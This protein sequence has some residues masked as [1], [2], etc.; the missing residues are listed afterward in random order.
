MSTSGQCCSQMLFTSG[1]AR[2]AMTH[3][4]QSKE[5]P[6][7]FIDSSQEDTWTKI[8]CNGVAGENQ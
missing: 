3:I 1:W 7:C 5:K 6:I 2:G 4:N 8:N